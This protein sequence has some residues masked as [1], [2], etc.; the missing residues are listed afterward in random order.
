MSKITM[1][2]AQARPTHDILPV[3]RFSIRNISKQTPNK[4]VKFNP[5]TIETSFG[6]THTPGRIK[7]DASVISSVQSKID[8]GLS[9]LA[10]RRKS[11]SN[12]QDQLNKTTTPVLSLNTRTTNQEQN[13][14]CTPVKKTVVN[15]HVKRAPVMSL[16]TKASQETNGTP[17]RRFTLDSLV[18]MT[19][20]CFNTVQIET[21]VA[22]VKT[23]QNADLND[24]EEDS[25]SVTVAVRVRP[26]SQR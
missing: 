24:S 1:M 20:E 15:D 9:N 10:S 11:D 13:Q 7:T 25:S 26:F 3:D 2:N 19:P 16:Q 5:Q 12:I 6:G 21:P 23:K 17:S 4:S 22:V 14:L 18:S 8:T